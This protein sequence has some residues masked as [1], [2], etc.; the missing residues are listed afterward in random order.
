MA[1]PASL[2]RALQA[3]AR[4]GD[5]A[6]MQRL[7]ARG[8]EPTAAAL[9]AAAASEGLPAEGVTALL[10]RGVRDDQA[11]NWA[12]RQGDTPVVAALRRAGVADVALPAPDAE[13]AG[14]ATVGARRHR[15][16]PAAAPA[17]R[18]GVPQDAPAASRATTTAC[19]R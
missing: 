6:G 11:M 1:G 9:R 18:Y 19:S 7:L 3:T 16:Q 14:D 5:S 10:E 2:T 4:Y 8:A 13:E 17:R 12:A 15:R